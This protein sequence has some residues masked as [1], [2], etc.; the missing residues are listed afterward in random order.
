MAK[1]MYKNLMTHIIK[2]KGKGAEDMYVLQHKS[3]VTAVEFSCY[4]H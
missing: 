3:N 1:C 2:K 4:E